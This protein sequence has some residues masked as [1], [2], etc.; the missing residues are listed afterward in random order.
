MGVFEMAESVWQTE[1]PGSQVDAQR[2]R[3]PFGQEENAGLA[4]MP[5]VSAN[6]KEFVR[7]DR[8]E[9][10]FSQP[11]TDARTHSQQGERDDA[12]KRASIKEI[13]LERNLALKN[14]GVR[15]VMDEDCPGPG[16]EKEWFAF[17]CEH[18]AL[19]RLA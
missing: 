13:E 9:E 7:G 8:L 17:A 6:V 15:F 12:D 11:P 1:G 19:A 2:I 3:K 16:G 10:P 18:P 5:D 4:H 14:A